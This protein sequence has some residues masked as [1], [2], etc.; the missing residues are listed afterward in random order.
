MGRGLCGGGGGD[1]GAT[2]AAAKHR[3]PCRHL[4]LGGQSGER[5]QHLHPAN[6]CFLLFDVE[7]EEEK[8]AGEGGGGC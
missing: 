1:S 6:I 7:M 5:R 2:T 3:F 8:E 4:L